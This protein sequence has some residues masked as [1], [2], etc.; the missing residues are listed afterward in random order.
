MYIS[1]ESLRGYILEEVLAFLI[2]ATGYRLLADASQDP[3]ELDR[4]GNGLVVKGR[5]GVHQVDVLGE[6]QWIPAFTF[7]LRLFVEAKFREGKTGIDTV[8]NAVA[9]LMDVNEKYSGTERQSLLPKYYRYVYA[10]FS[11]AGFSRNAA[12][13]AVAHQISLVDLSG[14]E[15][16][17]LRDVIRITADRAIA[18]GL[19]EPENREIF[20]ASVRNT[21]RHDLETWPT[22]VQNLGINRFPSLGQT[23][24]RVV[25]MARSYNELFVAVAEGPFMLLMKADDPHRFIEYAHRHPVHWIDIRWSRH[26]GNGQTWK[27]TSKDD[28]E[29]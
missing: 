17:S 3:T 14:D 15:F 19:A 6:L 28:G 22:E 11:A 24:S 2:R 7:P 12:R 26:I 25:E 1:T 4:R 18:D 16:Q 13:M 9:I 5:G 20:V 8:R 10:L 23:L 21:L 29:A 27:I